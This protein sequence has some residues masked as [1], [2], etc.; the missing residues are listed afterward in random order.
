MA[1]SLVFKGIIWSSIQ[2]FGNLL[3][4]FVANMVL[5]RLLTPD[6]FGIVG[7]LL[8]FVAI[9]QTLVDSGFGS[10]LI[11][12]KQIDQD[13]KSTVFIINLLMSVVLYLLVYLCAPWISAFYKIP[14]LCE[15]L[16]VI[17]LV[18]VINAFGQVQQSLLIRKLEF[19]KLSICNIMGSIVGAIIGIVSAYYGFGVWSLVIKTVVTALITNI[20]LWILNT[21]RPLMSFSVSSF[22]SLFS[23]G[24][25]IMLSNLILNVSNNIQSMIIGKYFAPSYVGN[26][27]Q[28]KNLR[29]VASD[30]ISAVIGSVL[31]PDFSKHQD[32]DILIN[33]RLEKSS[34]LLSYVV[35][36][37]MFFLIVGAN[38]IIPLVY[39]NQWDVAIPYFQILC[40]GGIPICLQRVNASVVQ[41]KG[42]SKLLFICNVIKITVYLPLL[43][44]AARFWSMTGFLWV[45]VFY[46]FLSYLIFALLAGYC[47]KSSC[48]PQII[49]IFKVSLLSFAASV[50]IYLLNVMVFSS[51]NEFLIVLADLLI[52]A[53]IYISLSI[54]FKFSAL[55][56]LL[57]YLNIKIK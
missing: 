56:D 44:I 48:I 16:R 36:P 20:L 17:S 40:V 24:G 57:S 2:K 29:N 43:I 19:R 21:W 12:K 55:T 27:T 30:G 4:S 6:D 10:A 34:A 51:F 28:A 46:S 3:I 41:A 53:T 35:I 54:L 5:A 32:N 45:M 18:V 13:D 31:Y 22:K 23:F 38:K 14:L 47:I 33:K 1:K 39:G 8:F 49:Y 37:L 7:M 9:A 50:I 42:R 11:Q 26:F 15:V 25:Y 52:F